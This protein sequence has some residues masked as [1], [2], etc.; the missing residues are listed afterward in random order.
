LNKQYKD[1]EA[2]YQKNKKIQKKILREFPKGAEVISAY[3]NKS[4][5]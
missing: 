3:K 5:I 1:L 2:N 4:K